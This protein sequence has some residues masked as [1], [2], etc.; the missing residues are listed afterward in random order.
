MGDARTKHSR[1]FDLQDEFLPSL[2]VDDVSVT[3]EVYEDVRPRLRELVARGFRRRAVR[4]VEA[5][6]HVSLELY[7]GDALGVIGRNGSGK[8]TLLRA[9]AGL[10]PP[11]TGSV[12]AQAVPVLLGVGAALNQ[13]LSG[14][15]NIL[16]GGAALGIP[17]D[18]MRDR[19]DEI[20]EFA[21]LTEFIDLPMRTYSSGMTARLTFS[22]A[23][24]ISPPVVMIDEALAVGDAEFK[25]RSRKRLEELLGQAG[26]VILVSHSMGA[27]TELCTRAIWMD[28][29]RVVADGDPDEVVQDYQREVKHGERRQI[30]EPE[31]DPPSAA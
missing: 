13:Q 28:R 18:V 25:E 21:G 24:S 1:A 14:R 16:L 30:R 3:F 27:I 10:I 2:V 9:M 8:S 31:D 20:A 29:G 12:Y 22:I 7:P 17:A 23:T 26:T 15:S 11:T 4:H 19:V 6:K 5:V